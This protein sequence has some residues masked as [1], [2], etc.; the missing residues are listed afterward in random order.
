[1]TLRSMFV[2]AL[3]NTPTL[4]HDLQ[5][6]PL[7]DTLKSDRP[8]KS[9]LWPCRIDPDGGG[10]NVDG[11]WINFDTNTFDKTAKPQVPGDVKWPSHF[12][13]TVKDG[14]RTFTGNNLPP[15]GTGIFP[16]PENSEAYRYDPNPNSI[17][18]QTLSF[19][20]PANPTLEPE[21]HCAPGAVGIMLS[22]IPLFSAIDAPGRD[23]VAHEVQD[24]CDGHPQPA[25][26]Y[27]YHSLSHC[28]ASQ[29]LVGYAIDGFGIYAGESADLDECHGTTSDIMWDGKKVSMYHYVATDDFPYTVGCLRGRFDRSTV[30]TLSGAPSGFFDFFKW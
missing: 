2:L 28:S 14:K 25:G 16:T 20:I 8:Q 22:G 24:K 6:L 10:A 5:H 26:V 11:P 1:M 9:H 4:A 29:G 19:S 21:A 3:L 27:H 13:V 18:G 7:G 30:E 17:A 23:A 15:H 12:V